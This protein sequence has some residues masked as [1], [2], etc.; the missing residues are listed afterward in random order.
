MAHS[1]KCTSLD[2]PGVSR[3]KS[4]H[5]QMYY[6]QI[7]PINCFRTNFKASVTAELTVDWIVLGRQL[8]CKSR[9]MF[10]FVWNL[11][12][13]VHL[14]RKSCPWGNATWG[15]WVPNTT[16]WYEPALVAVVFL[17]TYIEV[18]VSKYSLDLLL[19]PLTVI[20]KEHLSKNKE[21]KLY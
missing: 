4:P 8:L 11:P 17:V 2:L 1:A 12:R 13:F 9:K 19:W 16:H 21:I 14:S 10:F 3:W 20:V 5:K 7:V 18:Q 15:S 6:V